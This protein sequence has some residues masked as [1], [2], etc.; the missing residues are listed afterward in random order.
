MATEVTAALTQALPRP[1]TTATTVWVS[2]SRPLPET[3]VRGRRSP[4]LRLRVTVPSLS[5]FGNSR[6]PH[7]RS[8]RVSRSSLLRTTAAPG[9]K[10][11]S[12]QPVDRLRQRWP[13]RTPTPSWWNQLGEHVSNHPRG[14]LMASR[15]SPRH[16]ALR[17]RQRHSRRCERPHVPG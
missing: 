2:R 3:L 11:L 4:R 8:R 5:A 13:F 15:G 1:V 17:L 10:R 12:R 14:Q 6:N 7:L 16:A 9:H